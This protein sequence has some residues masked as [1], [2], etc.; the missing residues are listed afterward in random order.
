MYNTHCSV[1]GAAN[2][3]SFLKQEMFPLENRSQDCSGF[4]K[5]IILKKRDSIFERKRV[6]VKQ[7]TKVDLETEQKGKRGKLHACREELGDGGE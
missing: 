4:A 7:R 2:F 5:S 1:F 6:Q 3:K